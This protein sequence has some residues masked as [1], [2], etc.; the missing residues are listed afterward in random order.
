MSG[1]M[2]GVAYPVLAIFFMFQWLTAQSIKP[3]EQNRF[4][5]EYKGEPVLLL[6]GSVEDNLFQ[7]PD[8]EDHLDLL[9]AAGGNYVRCTMSSRDEGNLWPFH[10]DPS[11]G[12]YDLNHPN[13]EY[14]RRLE[15]FLEET[16]RR[17]IIVQIEVWA[18]FDFY[19]GNDMNRPF[20]QSNPFNPKNNRNYTSETSGLQEEMPC[21]PTGT[22]NPFFR[23]PPEGDDNALLRKFQERFV[24]WLLERSLKYPHVLYCMDNETSVDASW[25][26]YWA[27]YIRSKAGE[28][29]VQLTEMWDPWDLAHP[30]HNATFDHPELYDFVDVSQNNHQKGETHWLNGQ[31]QRKRIQD[32]GTIRPIN[33]VKIY[34]A[35][36]GRFGNDRDG[37]ER[38]W[39]N[40]IGGFASA[41]F[42][43]PDS[44]IGLSSEAQSHIR[45][46]RML[47]DRLGIF[48]VSPNNELLSDRGENEAFCTAQPGE[49]YAVFFPDGGEVRV[50]L[51]GE[52]RVTVEWLDAS[53]SR[54][55][56]PVE[57]RP[58]QFLSLKT[59]A[60]GY[61]AALVTRSTSP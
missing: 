48:D 32:S 53:R 37:I 5:W 31:R 3:Y 21:H 15:F 24:D 60:S 42:H 49:K 27:R 50:R 26:A 40:I 28:K 51:A 41:R 20:W 2:A 59:P 35:D 13:S 61:W 17:D 56:P 14:W 55:H 25:G 54:W 29:Q 1:R 44:G 18:T 39:R 7:I 6:G 22:C 10:R 4:Y 11:T 19:D 45:S 47:T 52:E 34:G 33:N 38:F 57:V 9:K 36:G 8:L 12:L 23:T 16:A 43:R 30:M 46:L 58:G